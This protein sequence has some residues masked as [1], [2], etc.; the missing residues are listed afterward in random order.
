[1]EELKEQGFN[2]LYIIFNDNKPAM[3]EYNLNDLEDIVIG[4]EHFIAIKGKNFLKCF[5]INFIK[6]MEYVKSANS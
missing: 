6:S 3:I 2:K 1:M 5:N 4:S